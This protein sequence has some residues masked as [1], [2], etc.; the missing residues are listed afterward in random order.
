MTSLSHALALAKKGFWVFPIVVGKKAPPCIR[1]WQ[2]AATRTE[3]DIIACWQFYDFNIG[4]Y[5]G[6]F[7]DNGEALIVLDVDVKN[8][9]VGNE[10]LI[11]LELEGCTW[12]GTYVQTTPTGGRHLVFRTHQAVKSGASVCGRNLDIRSAGGYIVGAGS[13][14]TEGHYTG[15]DLPVADAPEWLI[16]KCGS[17]RLVR[18]A[19]SRSLAL[20]LD[21]NTAETRA[22]AY[23]QDQAPLAIQGAG[24]DHTTYTVAARCKDFGC[25]PEGTLRLMLAWWNER[26]SPPW[27]DIE[28]ETKIRHAFKYGANPIG[29]DAPE[30][31]FSVVPAS[32]AT[33]SSAPLNP[34]EKLNLEYAY[35]TSGGAQIVLWDTVDYRG[36]ARTEH[37]SLEAFHGRL[38][39]ER[40]QV[41]NGQTIQLSK[42]WFQSPQRRS[43]DGLVFA[44][45]QQLPPRWYNLWRGFAVEPSP[46]STHPMVER[47]LEHAYENVCQ[48]HE[49][50]YEWL[51]DYFAHMVQKPWEKPLVA[52]V[53]R[54]AKGVGKNALVERIGALFGS[55][56]LL[57][58]TRRY[59]VGNFNS[60]LERLIFFVL[61]EAFWSGDKQSEGVLKDLITGREHVI[62][63]KGHEPYT[64]ANKLRVCIIG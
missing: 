56:Y 19:A 20:A 29:V 31:A 38:A 51:I 34:V 33:P 17:G 1:D 55:H 13:A 7:G 48:K 53:M 8:G 36:N 9:G 18:Q 61:D 25:T 23:L 57:S 15:N 22:E 3:Q 37:L 63:R 30:A 16:D 46:I 52:L 45:E 62:E 6:K 32:A 42:M 58:A 40:V 60:H 4:I 14:T 10:E 47:F 2:S 54:G 49:P 35:V 21:T 11:R 43:Y 12:P 41:G 27:T 39:S 44:P 28:L 59:L 24:G 26:C 5:T 64:V 50:L